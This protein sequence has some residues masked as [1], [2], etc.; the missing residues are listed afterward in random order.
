MFEFKKEFID[1]VYNCLDSRTPVRFFEIMKKLTRSYSTKRYE[2]YASSRDS[3]YHAT[4][5]QRSSSNT[6][7]GAL[8]HDAIWGTW[9]E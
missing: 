3:F 8:H 2:N 1:V 6:I 4:Q 5:S 7:K 9:A